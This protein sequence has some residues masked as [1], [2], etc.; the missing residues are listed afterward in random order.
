M[1][2]V[3][4]GR[5]DWFPEMGAWV[6]RVLSMFPETSCGIPERNKGFRKWFFLALRTCR[7]HAR[8]P[9]Y[10]RVRRTSTA[11]R[12]PLLA[13]I[14][15]TPLR[16]ALTPPRP[17]DWPSGGGVTMGLGWG[18]MT[19]A[20]VRLRSPVPGSPLQ[21]SPGALCL[22]GWV[23]IVQGDGNGHGPRAPSAPA[24]GYVS[25]PPRLAR[26]KPIWAIGGAPM[27][28]P[29]QALRAIELSA[30]CR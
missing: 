28:P 25:A 27:A 14:R 30:S 9:S 26:A 24:S 21:D 8:R 22:G 1:Y 16:G 15:R 29:A 10:G 11:P 6:L 19:V 2:G 13:P 5:I 7:E 18:S 23:P 4:P 3:V 17:H 20:S 12:T